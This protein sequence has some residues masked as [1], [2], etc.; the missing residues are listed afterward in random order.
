MGQWPPRVGDAVAKGLSAK[1]TEPPKRLRS[2]LSGKQGSGGLGRR[3]VL[4]RRRGTNGAA[5]FGTFR[6][7][8]RTPQL[9]LSAEQGAPNALPPSTRF[10]DADDGDC[11]NSRPAQSCFVKEF[12]P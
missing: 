6:G 3:G 11:R 7:K 1:M 10:V 9:A 4:E 5:A 2:R 12:F 8:R